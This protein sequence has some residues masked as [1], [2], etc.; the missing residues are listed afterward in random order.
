MT[1]IQK[2]QELINLLREQRTSVIC[3]AVTKGIDS[4]C[5]NERQRQ[6]AVWILVP[7]HW[8]VV[9]VKALFGN[10]AK[11]SA[12]KTDAQL[13]ASQ[14][15]GIISQDDY[16]ERQNYTIVWPDK[17]GL[18]TGSTLRQRFRQIS[19]CVAF[20]AGWRDQLYSGCI[21]ALHRS[22]A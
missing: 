3:S 22:E 12:M 16:M 14:K 7:P 9:P 21:T 8:R 2:K 5:R 1:L 20:K 15:Y 13:T 19:V 11:K 6:R 4:Y 18:K 17:K 10:R